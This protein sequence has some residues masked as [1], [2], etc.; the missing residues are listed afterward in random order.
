M[1]LN[2]DYYKTQRYSEEIEIDVDLKE[3]GLMLDKEG[4]IDEKAF[5]SNYREDNEDEAPYDF[6][7]ALMGLFEEVEEKL[8]N[9]K[10]TVLNS[11]P[12][13]VIEE[14]GHI[15]YT[16]DDRIIYESI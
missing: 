3:Y 9:N 5:Y 12:G 11:T 16:K 8:Y 13:D 4:N 2:L 15:V 6:D 7:D 14:F 10:Y 1:K